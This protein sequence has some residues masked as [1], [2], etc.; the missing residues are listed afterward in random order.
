MPHAM[1][2]QRR[3]VRLGE[4]LHPVASRD[5]P[6]PR[7]PKGQRVDQRLAQD[8]GLSRSSRIG[9]AGKIPDAAMRTG[10]IQVQR[11]ARPQP[12]RHLAAIQPGH[13]ARRVQHRDHQRARKMLVP[14]RPIHPQPLQPRPQLRPLA[15]PLVRQ[16]Q[17]QGPVGEAQPEGRDRLGIGDAACF[18]VRQRRRRARQARLVVADHPVQHRPVVLVQRHRHGQF[19]H[20]RRRGGSSGGE[21][22][23]VRNRAIWHWATRRGQAL[24]LAQQLDGVAEADAAPLHYP[25]DRPAGRAAAEAVPEVLGWRHHQRRLGIR[26]QRAQPH[27]VTTP[28]RQRHPVGR[29][30]LGYRHPRLQPLQLRLGHPRHAGSPPTKPLPGQNPSIGIYELF[31]SA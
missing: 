2:P 23:M 25:V 14:A 7:A 24:L 11:R 13:P 31:M 5:M 30:Q 22:R 4:P 16:P 8:H 18:E 12:R 15:T 28:P 29:H 21:G 10:Q 3:Q 20:R 6:I 17:A 19:P 26:V 9:D 27:Q 1:L